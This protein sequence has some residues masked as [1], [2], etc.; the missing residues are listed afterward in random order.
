MRRTKSGWWNRSNSYGRIE[1]L[2]RNASRG[3][4]KSDSHLETEALRCLPEKHKSDSD[5][6]AGTWRI[7]NRHNALMHMPPSIL[8]RRTTRNLMQQLII[9]GRT[10]GSRLF[11]GTGK[12]GSTSTMEQAILASCSELVT[13]ALKRID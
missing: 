13:V 2:Y 4:R 12:F 6:N 9:A 5:V 10:F 8:N 3:K 7:S 11:T 1:R